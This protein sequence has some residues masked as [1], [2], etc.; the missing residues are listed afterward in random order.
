VSADQ[1]E[2]AAGALG[3]ILDEVVFLGGASIHLWLS[4]PA[5]PPTRATDDVD[6]ISAITTRTGYYRL[7]KR[8]RTRGF[9]EASDSNIICRWRH[10]ETGLLLDVM[11][12]EPAVLGFSNP[13]YQHAI[14]TAI[15]RQLPS[16]TGIRAATPP[17]IIATKLVAW[18]G[19]GKGDMLASLDLHDILVLIDGR[20]ELPSEIAAEPEAI[21]T[22]I[23]QEL[24]VLREDRYF[25]YLIESAL[26]G[27]GQLAP[28]RVPYVQAHIDKLTSPGQ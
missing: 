14:E 8:L 9:I 5:A 4:D 6:V 27:Y 3:P 16:G 1:L 15:D 20:P 10:Q 22:Y 28:F 7:A 25:L 13:W 23:A 26:H 2:T 18:R 24:G 12:Q 19:R 11:P 17:S 21:R